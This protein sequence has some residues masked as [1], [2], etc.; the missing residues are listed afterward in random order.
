L[1][2]LTLDAYIKTA[3]KQGKKVTEKGKRPIVA[4]PA[5]R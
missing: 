4:Y 3:G 2:G 1:Y 5:A